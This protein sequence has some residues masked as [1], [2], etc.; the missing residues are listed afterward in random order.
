MNTFPYIEQGVINSY[1][2]DEQ[3]DKFMKSMGM[4]ISSQEILLGI[5]S[6]YCFNVTRANQAHA[7]KL[8]Q[9]IK[10]KIKCNTEKRGS[11]NDAWVCGFNYAIE[12]ILGEIK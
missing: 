4:D 6:E 11:Y 12:E 5:I 9:L 8:T 10:S 3:L 7:I 2:L 1:K